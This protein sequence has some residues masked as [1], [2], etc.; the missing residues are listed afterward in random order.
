MSNLQLELLKLY[1]TNL[2]EAQLLDIKKLLADYFARQIDIEM[3]T[4]WTERGWNDD[5]IEAWKH[6]RLRTPYK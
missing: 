6:E 1:A 3:N 2:P 5:T 4:L